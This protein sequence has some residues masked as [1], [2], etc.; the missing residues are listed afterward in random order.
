MCLF[1]CFSPLPSPPPFLP[2]FPLLPS[3]F[4][5]LFPSIL[6]FRHLLLIPSPPPSLLI[7]KARSF[8]HLLRSAVNA[9]HLFRA[10]Q[11]PP[12]RMAS[13]VAMSAVRRFLLIPAAAIA[14]AGTAMT[15]V[16]S[17]AEGREE[18]EGEGVNRREDEGVSPFSFFPSAP[19]SHSSSLSSIQIKDSIPNIGI[20]GE[21]NGQ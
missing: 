6:P 9:Q 19:S 1:R 7:A 4:F 17:E 16:R 20:P 2:L 14:A 15:A 11:A 8:H 13:S 5:H 10:T 12:V 18:R 21:G 3:L